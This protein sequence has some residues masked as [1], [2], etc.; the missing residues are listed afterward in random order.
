MQRLE[1]PDPD[2]K[3]TKAADLVRRQPRV[4]ERLPV[5]DAR[6]GHLDQEGG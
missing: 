3:R 4:K 1:E 2:D 5:N 6:A